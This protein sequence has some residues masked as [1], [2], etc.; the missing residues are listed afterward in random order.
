MARTASPLFVSPRRSLFLPALY[1]ALLSFL[2]LALDGEDDVVALDASLLPRETRQHVVHEDLVVLPAPRAPAARARV[3][4]CVRVCVQR[5]AAASRARTSPR[6]RPAQAACRGW[7][8]RAGA[9]RA[10]SA[11]RQLCRALAAPPQGIVRA[12]PGDRSESP[13]GPARG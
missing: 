10:A 3:T 2:H 9:P 8:R 1:S 4:S 11:G 6:T 5:R 12:G 7:A 13:P